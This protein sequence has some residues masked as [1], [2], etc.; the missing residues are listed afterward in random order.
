[1]SIRFTINEKMRQLFGI[2]S[3]VKGEARVEFCGYVGL[4]ENWRDFWGCKISVAGDEFRYVA[5]DDISFDK[6][7]QS[8]GLR[9]R[10]CQ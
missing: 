4:D 2:G 1:M 9:A 6:A 3:E 10:T 8:C 7:M 5:H